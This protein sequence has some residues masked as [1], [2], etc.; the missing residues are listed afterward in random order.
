M[1]VSSDEDK[2]SGVRK[3]ASTLAYAYCRKPSLAEAAHILLL[4]SQAMDFD[5]KKMIVNY[6][7]GMQPAKLGCVAGC[8]LHI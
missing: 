7:T 3:R 1:V 6:D 4:L 5:R 2:E 8:R